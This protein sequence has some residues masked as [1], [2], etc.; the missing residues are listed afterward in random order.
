MNLNEWLE[1][2]TIWRQSQVEMSQ[3]KR[4]KLFHYSG[5]R[6]QNNAEHTLG[7]SLLG[8]MYFDLAH[9]YSAGID[10][11]L[12]LSALLIHDISEGIMGR[13]IPSPQKT[14]QDDLSEYNAFV[15]RFKFLGSDKP[16]L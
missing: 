10:Q 3:V 9:D 4:W 6:I 16:P 15:E 8:M 11:A 13:D 2:M 5:V 12:V 1:V 14:F 7:I